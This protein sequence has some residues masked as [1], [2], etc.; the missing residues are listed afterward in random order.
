M[1][2]YTK[3]YNQLLIKDLRNKKRNYKD[4][5]LMTKIEN[6]RMV[7]IRYEKEIGVHFCFCAW[8]EWFCQFNKK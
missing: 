2:I 1:K 7:F 4:N 6:L 3:S 8:F 5:N